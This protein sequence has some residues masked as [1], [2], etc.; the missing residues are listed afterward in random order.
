[1]RE[2]SK[3]RE[4]DAGLPDGLLREAVDGLYILR[5]QGLEPLTGLSYGALTRHGGVS[6]H[7]C[8]SLNLSYNTPDSPENVRENLERVRSAFKAEKLF[9]SSQ[10]HGESFFVVE[11]LDDEVPQGTDGLF[12]R[13]SGAAL[14]IKIGD[15]QSIGLFDPAA[16]VAGNV[17]TGWRGLVHSVPAKA[18]EFMARNFGTDPKSLVA[19]VSPSLGP[20]CF[21]F[22]GYEELLDPQLHRFVNEDAMFDFWAATESTL[23]DAGLRSENIFFMKVCTRC[24]THDFFSY[25][26]QGE[27]GRFGAVIKLNP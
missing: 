20:C 18:V 5:H 17:H 16:H 21:E 13:V 9:Y 19:A 25:R 1:M 27:T 7:P 2:Y 24:S 11:E 8:D 6:P 14:L 3:S 4:P 22:R 15:C 12:T 23:I 10:V 26:A